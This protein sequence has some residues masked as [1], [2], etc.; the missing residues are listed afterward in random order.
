MDFTLLYCNETIS[1]GSIHINNVH[2]NYAVGSGFV[3]YTE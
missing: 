3:V 1:L 2:F